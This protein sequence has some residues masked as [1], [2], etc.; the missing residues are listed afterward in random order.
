MQT[1]E[2]IHDTFDIVQGVGA[3]GMARQL[4]YLP[5]IQC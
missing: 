5:G 1:L 3:Q 4:G 2:I